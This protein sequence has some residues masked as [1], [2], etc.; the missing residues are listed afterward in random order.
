MQVSP[1]HETMP[2]LSFLNDNSLHV[3]Q[4]NVPLGTCYHASLLQSTYCFTNLRAL[5]VICL[6][7]TYPYDVLLLQRTHCYASF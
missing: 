6:L 2:M 3:S 1:S 5:T 4:S 7:L